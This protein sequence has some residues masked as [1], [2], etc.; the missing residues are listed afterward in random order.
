MVAYA[1]LW[2]LGVY[3]NVPTWY[4]AVLGFGFACKII[5]YGLQMYKEGRKR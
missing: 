1:L 2:Y 3:L 4:Y 5:S